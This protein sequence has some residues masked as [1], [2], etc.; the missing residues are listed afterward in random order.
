MIQQVVHDC[1]DVNQKVPVP[2]R[3]VSPAQLA[4]ARC[5]NS[6]EFAVQFNSVGAY[7]LYKYAYIHLSY[8]FCNAH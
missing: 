4:R 6:K 3:K 7:S 1:S 8:Q 5:A 2:T